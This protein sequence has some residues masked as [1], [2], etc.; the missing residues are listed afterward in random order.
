[1][2]QRPDR[3]DIL[4]AGAGPVGLM[5]AAR[6]RQLGVDIPGREYRLSLSYDF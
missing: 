2:A 1:M 4:I 6:L 3:T 5:A